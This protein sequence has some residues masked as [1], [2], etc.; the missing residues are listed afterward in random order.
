MIFE[1]EGTVMPVW[2][3]TR[4]D[5][6]YIYVI[7]HHGQYKIGR[8]SRAKGRIRAAQT[9][10]P[11]MNLVGFKP[12]WGISH[13]ERLLHIGFANYWYG[14]E[15]YRFDGDDGGREYF[16]DGFTA[17]SDDSPDRNSRDFIYWYNEGMVEFLAE[18][19]HQKVSLRKFQKQE[20][21]NRGAVR[22]DRQTAGDA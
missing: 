22:R 6:G 16:I 18:M 9:W 20:S 21:V 7:E 4:V 8:T 13:H 19:N 1:K 12:F 2:G 14:G 11:D 3:I 5:P 17:F 10:L 15:W